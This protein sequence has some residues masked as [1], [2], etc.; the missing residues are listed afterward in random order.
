M[1]ATVP[2]FP[3]VTRSAERCA[4]AVLL[5]TLGACATPPPP[6]PLPAPQEPP[7]RAP[8]DV[9]L[10]LNLPAEDA[11][12]ACPIVPENDRTFL[13]KGVERLTAGDYVEAVQ[14]FQRYRRLEMNPIAQWEAEVGIAYASMLPA[15]PFYDVPAARGSYLDLQGREPEGPKHHAIVLM[16]QALESFV[17]MDR[18]I[19]DLENRTG[20]L[21][22]DLEKREQA[23]KR[24]RE[25]TLGQPGG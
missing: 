2:F 19:E 3:L 21:E 22:E 6:A 17:L 10:T 8:E 18:H 4:L 5:L 12:C 7:S 14:Y 11:D 1:K 13:E 20:M 25:L 24:L 15:S 23:L 9:K 16:Q